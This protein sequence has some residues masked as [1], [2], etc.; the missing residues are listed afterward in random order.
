MHARL[1]SVHI[2]LTVVALGAI[3]ATYL[4]ATRQ[5]RQLRAELAN[6]TAALDEAV[7]G[8]ARANSRIGQCPQAATPT[9]RLVSI[10]RHSS[11]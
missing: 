10:P 2:A 7:V 5:R 9:A 11:N 8:I 6:T 3:A 1:S 4:A